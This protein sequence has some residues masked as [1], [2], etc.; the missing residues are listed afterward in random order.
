MDSVC[1][2]PVD[3]IDGTPT[4]RISAFRRGAQSNSVLLVLCPSELQVES[5]YEG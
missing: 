4:A 1:Q 5:E 2:N 3:H